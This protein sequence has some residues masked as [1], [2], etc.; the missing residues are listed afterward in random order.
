MSDRPT[1]LA[2]PV[3]HAATVVTAL[4]V[5]MGSVVCATES[6][7]ACPSWPGCN[8]GQVTPDARTEPVI[9][10]VHRVVAILAGPLIVAAAGLSLRLPRTERLIRILPWVAVLGALAAAVFGRQV[11]L[12]GLPPALGVLD[13]G[14]SLTAMIAI[15][16]A[17]VALARRPYAVYF[18]PTAKLAWSGVAVLMVMHLLGILTAGAGSFTRCMGWPIWRVIDSDQA[19]AVQWLRIVL[20]AAAT[21]LILATSLAARGRRDLRLTAITLPVLYA[22]ELALGLAMGGQRV[23]MAGAALYSTL[24][25]GILFT[26]S[27]LAALATVETVL[28]APDRHLP[29]EDADTAQGSETTGPVTAGPAAA[30]S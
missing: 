17:T 27:L 14:L 30:G 24:A 20:A 13:L 12:H 10:F 1:P 16:T 21:A 11:V 26:L 29:A 8:T 18:S 19:P 2:R 15:A 25:V 6:G 4:A 9:E 23:S 3:F 5:V 28:P 7:M 22:A